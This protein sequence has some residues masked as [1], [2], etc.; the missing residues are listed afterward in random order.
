MRSRRAEKGKRPAPPTLGTMGI[1]QGLIAARPRAQ[2]GVLPRGPSRRFPRR[3]R[4]AAARIAR[5][6]FIGVSEPPLE[7][8][9][10]PLAARPCAARAVGGSAPEDGRRADAASLDGRTVA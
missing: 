8:H 6:V 10:V 4:P 2:L 1:A 9:V 5:P 7:S 3:H